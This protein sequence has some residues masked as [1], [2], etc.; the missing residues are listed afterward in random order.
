MF[1]LPPFLNEI[2]EQQFFPAFT[3]MF[4]FSERY[5]FVFSPNKT[6][7]SYSKSASVGTY[8]ENGGGQDKDKRNALCNKPV[9]MQALCN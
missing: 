8:R 1:L 2:S 9:N 7:V 3:Q 6:K 4:F 5:L